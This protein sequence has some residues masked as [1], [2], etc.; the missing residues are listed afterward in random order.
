MRTGQARPAQVMPVTGAA[1][2]EGKGR[3]VQGRGERRRLVS[4]SPSLSS[5]P[6]QCCPTAFWVSF[7]GGEDSNRTEGAGR[8]SGGSSGGDPLE[9]SGDGIFMSVVEVVA[10]PF[11]MMVTPTVLV[12]DSGLDGAGRQQNTLI[13]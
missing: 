12:E 3:G 6:L 4:P 1:S 11:Q 10:K 8:A 13:S 5:S 9:G 2:R 7:A